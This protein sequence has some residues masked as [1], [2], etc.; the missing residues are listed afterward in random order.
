MTN[1]TRSSLILFDVDATLITTSRSGMVAMEE[2][3]RELFGARFTAADAEFAGRLDPLILA[4]LLRS[5][6]QEASA[7]NLD[8]MRACYGRHLKRRLEDPSLAQP[9]PGVME[10]LKRLEARAIAAGLLTGNYPE[11]GRMKL[12]ASGIDPQRFAVQV[13][14][15]CSPHDVPCRTHLPAVAMERYRARYGPIEPAQV[16]IIG[17]TP[18]DV[19]AARAH[20]CRS[21][22]VATGMHTMEQLRSARADEV[23]ENL[24]HT[25]RVEAWLLA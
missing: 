8:A 6:G 21:L 10:L 11:T 3:G 5:N 19:A 12:R 15:D 16:T 2:A 17:D 24:A 25:S 23:L 1:E 7:A 14:G 20:G 18:H 9:L 22:G 4:D 13:W